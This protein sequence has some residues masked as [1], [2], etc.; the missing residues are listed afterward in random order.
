MR[1]GGQLGSPPAIGPPAKFWPWQLLGA[2][3]Q[4][5]ATAFMLLAMNDRSFVVTTAYISLKGAVR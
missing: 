1:A 4:I 2:L 3:S 5:A